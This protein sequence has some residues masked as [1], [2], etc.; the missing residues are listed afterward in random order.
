M[1]ERRARRRLTAF[2][3]AALFGALAF[4][5]PAHAATTCA[6]TFTANWRGM[7]GTQHLWQ[8]D[9]K[10]G[11]TGTVASTNWDAIIG[12]A[13]SQGAVVQRYWN[14]TRPSTYQWSPAAWNKIIPAGQSAYFGFEILVPN[15]TLSP[16]PTA[17]GCSI[18]Y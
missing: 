15:A 16:L 3:L 7:V 2:L 13:Y 1:T 10:F 18:T 12:F 9:A 11:N 17:V 8:V 6:L 4:V 14:I 5:T